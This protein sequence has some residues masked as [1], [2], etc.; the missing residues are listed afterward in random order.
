MRRDRQVPSLGHRGDLARL[1][2]AAAPGQVEHHDAGGVRFEQ[3]AE[4]PAGGQ[5]FGRAERSRA[6]GCIALQAR[7]RIHLDRIFVPEGIKGVSALA[8]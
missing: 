1:G 3:I 6:L 7:Q 4:G 5:R 8:I 2:Q